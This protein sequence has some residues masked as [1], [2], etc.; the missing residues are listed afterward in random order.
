VATVIYMVLFAV[1]VLTFRTFARGV[2]ALEH[3]P[4]NPAVM[5]LQLKCHIH[6]EAFSATLSK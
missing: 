6:R 5:M 1:I 4:P 2:P 3:S